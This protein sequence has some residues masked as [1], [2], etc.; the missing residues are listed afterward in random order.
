M[1]TF[2]QLVDAMVAET[3]R[4]DLVSEITSYLNQ[5]IREVHFTSDRNAALFY[6]ENFREALLTANVE[7]GFGWAIPKPT[8]FQKMQVVQYST[9]V[10]RQRNP[11]YAVETTP[12]RHLSGIEVFFY[13]AG[14]TFVFSGYGGNTSQIAIGYYEFPPSLLYK[15]PL[16]RP[17][18]YDPETG[19]TYAAGVNTPELQ[20]AAQEL[21]TNWLLM[22]WK[23]VIAEGVRAKVYK[24]VADPDRARTSYSMFGSLRQGLWTSETAA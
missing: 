24:R 12:G 18:T 23:D 5:T 22:R 19:W 3:K 13:R 17:A 15:T 16:Q 10:D 6:S 20:L 14:G 8:V 2:S 4:S 9:I 1:T 7:S 21:T 11:V